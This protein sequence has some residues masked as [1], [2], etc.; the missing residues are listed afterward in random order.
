VPLGVY[1]LVTTD[2]GN[3]KFW[4]G[5]LL[6]CYGVYA[7]AAPKPSA[8][9]AGGRAADGLVGFAGGVIGGIAG[10]AGILTVIWTQI[11]GW[12]KDTA[13][14]I[15]QS[16]I[17]FAHVATLVCLGGVALD[18]ASLILLA[19]EIPV[20]LAGAAAGWALFGKLNE[21]GFRF[22]LA[23]LVLLSGAGLIL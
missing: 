17:I 13:R 2:A 15:Y 9:V 23:V 5:I 19:L 18:R 4:L 12:P 16:Y 21:R 1:L 3:L 11:R 20:L 8:I 22:A 7:L 6:V 14:G 10:F